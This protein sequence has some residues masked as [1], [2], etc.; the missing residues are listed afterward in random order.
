MSL[1][2]TRVRHRPAILFVGIVLAMLASGVL[3]WAATAQMLV[4]IA[5]VLGLAVLVMAG[6]AIDRL[7][8]AAPVAAYAEPDWSVTVAAIEQPG[9]SIAIT[10]RANRLVCANSAYIKRFGIENAPPNL[11]LTQSDVEEIGRAHV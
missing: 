6:F 9:A 7:R 8:S 1:S 11:L 10:D 4:A 5:Y 3:L 2:D